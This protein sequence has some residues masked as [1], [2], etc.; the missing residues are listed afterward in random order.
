MST[1][2][3]DL[4]HSL[5]ERPIWAAYSD[6]PQEEESD[7]T[8]EDEDEESPEEY[9]EV[10]SEQFASRWAPVDIGTQIRVDFSEESFVITDAVILNEFEDLTRLSTLP[11]R[12]DQPQVREFFAIGSD[13]FEILVELGKS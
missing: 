11:A 7:D 8:D 9:S 4:L 5:C 3:S 10:A 6:E 2:V 13:G 12:P 1:P